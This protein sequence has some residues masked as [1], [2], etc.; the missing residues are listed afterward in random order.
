MT[1]FEDI[2]H[3]KCWKKY[4]DVLKF[5]VFWENISPDPFSHTHSTHTW[6]KHKLQ[7]SAYILKQHPMSTFEYSIP[8]LFCL[9]CED[10]GN[11]SDRSC[12]LSLSHPT[13]TPHPFYF[14]NER[15]HWIKKN[16]ISN[17]NLT[18]RK[19]TYNSLLLR[20]VYYHY[21][22]WSITNAIFRFQNRAFPLSFLSLSFCLS[23]SWI[24]ELIG[25]L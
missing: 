8:K 9:L 19:Q 22:Y 11:W 4:A 2:L 24:S 21:Y 23:S 13:P 7:W 5:N 15:S 6:I 25:D 10:P 3:N 1:G 14:G 17:L 16:N 12:P 20:A 18:I